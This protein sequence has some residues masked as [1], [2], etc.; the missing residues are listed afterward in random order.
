MMVVASDMGR[1]ICKSTMAIG[2][3]C[4]RSHLLLQDDAYEIPQWHLHV[5]EGELLVELETDSVALASQALK[6]AR[7]AEAAAEMRWGLDW[8]APLAGGKLMG[9]TLRPNREDTAAQLDACSSC[10]AR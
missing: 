9:V 3:C 6:P 1:F 5:R 8:R 4:R 10:V 2:L 7:D